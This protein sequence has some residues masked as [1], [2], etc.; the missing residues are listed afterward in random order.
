VTT[1]TVNI[2]A[3]QTTQPPP[4]SPIVGMK[5]ASPTG[6][7]YRVSGLADPIRIAI[8]D[9]GPMADGMFAQCS[10]WDETV[11]PL[12]GWSTAGC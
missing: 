9:P 8:P 11:E 12:G 10:Y 6:S 2:Y 5:L 7:A 4:V 1:W 3:G